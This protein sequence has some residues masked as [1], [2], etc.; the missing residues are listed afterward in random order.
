MGSRVKLR[1]YRRY[2]ANVSDHRPVSA[3]FDITV[4]VVDRNERERRKREVERI[5]V[6][7]E[8]RLLKSARE[9]YVSQM[10]L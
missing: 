3:S 4:K 8:Q 9:F 6:G 2:E 5:W 10:L 1:E 7:V